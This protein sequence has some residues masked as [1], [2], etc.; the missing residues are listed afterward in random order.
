MGFIPSQRSESFRWYIKVVSHISNPHFSKIKVF[1][2]LGGKSVC[3][4]GSNENF[5]LLLVQAVP[6]SRRI[7]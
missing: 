2:R 1:T 7:W 6:S 3:Y 4:A 5:V